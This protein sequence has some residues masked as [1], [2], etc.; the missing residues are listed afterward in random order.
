MSNYTTKCMLL[1]N[2]EANIINLDSLH[3]KSFD[4]I[5]IEV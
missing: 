3:Q 2:L 5:Q 1:N 4:K